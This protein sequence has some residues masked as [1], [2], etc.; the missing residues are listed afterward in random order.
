[1][2]AKNEE[3]ESR[4]ENISKLIQKNEQLNQQVRVQKQRLEKFKAEQ[5]A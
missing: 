3:L 1:V 4:L 2:A 5:L